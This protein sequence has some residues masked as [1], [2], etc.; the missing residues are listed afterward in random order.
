[1]LHLS[2]LN[3]YRLYRL[4][5]TIWLCFKLQLHVSPVNRRKKVAY[6]PPLTLL[7]NLV[8]VFILLTARGIRADSEILPLEVS[9]NQKFQ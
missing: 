3:S 1:M 8:F 2:R 4:V 9:S 5:P 6:V 7:M